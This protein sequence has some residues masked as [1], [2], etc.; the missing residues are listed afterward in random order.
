MGGQQRKNLTE[1]ER[2]VLKILKSEPLTIKQ[3][4]RRRHT[5]LQ[6]TYKLVKSMV[7]KGYVRHIGTLVVEYTYGGWGMPETDHIPYKETDKNHPIRLHGEAYRIDVLRSS[8]DWDKVRV[9]T[10]IIFQGN[11]VVA[12][13]DCLMVF[14]LQSFE[15][16]TPDECDARA[17]RYWLGYF[18]GLERRYGITILR[19]RSQNIRR[20]R[21]HYAETNNELAQDLRKKGET[22]VRV[23][24]SR[25]GKEW[26][27]FDD[28]LHLD[29]AET[30][31]NATPKDGRTAKEDMQEVIQPFFND[32]RDHRAEIPLPSQQ[33]ATQAH[34]E[35]MM[36]QIVKALEQQV[37]IN[38]QN[39]L[40]PN[41]MDEEPPGHGPKDSP[42]KKLDYFG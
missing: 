16:A 30:T 31:H 3:I 14:S 22:K 5:S 6:A 17:V 18:H 8:P 28:S 7:E 13:R 21:S 36:A 29:E 27:L 34:H 26:L 10:S 1:A 12:Y 40:K 41:Q 4:S 39:Q 19:E 42:L 33:A 9:S 24:G 35:R 37:L 15:G 38:A 23:F 20:V 32:L 25:D 2:D 11:T